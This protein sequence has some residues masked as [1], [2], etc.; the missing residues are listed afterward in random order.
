MKKLKT[1]KDYMLFDDFNKNNHFLTFSVNYR[2]SYEEL[3]AS[4][5]ILEKYLNKHNININDICLKIISILI[6]DI[7][8]QALVY[9]YG[10][11]INEKD[12]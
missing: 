9:T 11:Y 10:L 4:K 6:I 3:R 1:F 12:G 5:D 2:I 8:K 7:K